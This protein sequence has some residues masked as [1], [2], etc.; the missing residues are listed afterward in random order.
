M[1]FLCE[2]NSFERNSIFLP[3]YS[4]RIENK[5]ER[6]TLRLY[7]VCCVKLT[8]RA[9]NKFYTFYIVYSLMSSTLIMVE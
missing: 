4:L 5:D 8:E 7:F 6:K 2:G 3:L 1:D 9:E